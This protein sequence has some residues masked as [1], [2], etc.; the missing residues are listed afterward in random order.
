MSDENTGSI[1]SE[2]ILLLG[3]GFTK[4][5]GGLLANEMW[6]EIFNHKE[7]QAQSRIKKLMLNDFDY[8]CVYYSVLEGFKDK[9]GLLGKIGESIAFEKEEKDTIEKA[10]TAA[11]M[12][13]DEILREHV[14]NHPRPIELNYFNDLIYQ[15][16]GQ[17]IR[18]EKFY[19]DEIF[20]HSH[21]DTKK[22]SFI[23]TLNQD[24]L[25]ERLFPKNC[26]ANLSIPGIDNN[27]E[28]FTTCFNKP[29]EELDYCKLPN[30]DQLSN[31]DILLE[32]SYFLIKLHGSCNWISYDGS[33]VMVIG[34]GKKGKIHKEPL[35]K[36]YFEIF[37]NVLSQGRR[38]LFIIGYGFGDKHVN[39]IISKAIIKH[40]L[41]VYILS[42]ESPN[43]FKEKLC[44]GSEKSEDTINIWNGISGYFQCVEEILINS[45]FKNQ[46]KKKRFY[47]VFFD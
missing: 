14:I 10:T 22:K 17:S 20:Y 26:C 13:I 45:D 24:L 3:A 44:N 37:E 29:L 39:K 18:Y 46:A 6:A 33:E 36:L 9:E 25:F 23:F 47:D 19:R 43:T 21:T 30:E 15:I 1:F 5:F 40:E 31:K 2:D 8:E 35:L 4:N 16:G 27:P 32:G 42:P 34:R 28:W 12:Y 7:I 11:Y 41:K 38:R